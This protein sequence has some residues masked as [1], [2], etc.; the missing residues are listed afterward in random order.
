MKK[1]HVRKRSRG[2][3]SSGH[4]LTNRDPILDPCQWD[5]QQH[6]DKRV[7]SEFLQRYKTFVGA[8]YHTVVDDN[9]IPKLLIYDGRSSMSL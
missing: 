3:A 7:L 8:G 1:K 2:L 4:S 9:P 6:R 5:P